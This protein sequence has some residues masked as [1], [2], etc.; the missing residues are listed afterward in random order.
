MKINIMLIILLLTFSSACAEALPP[1]MEP[2]IPVVVEHNDID[3]T[4][5]YKLNR[6]QL[7]EVLVKE[8]I[9]TYC[10]APADDEEWLLEMNSQSNSDFALVYSDQSGHVGTIC[11]DYSGPPSPAECHSEILDLASE[12]VRS[13]LESIGLAN[14]EYPFFYCDYEYKTFVGSTWHSVT[15]VEYLDCGYTSKENQLQIWDRLGGPMVYV[16]V[17]FKVNEYPLA[18]SISWTDNTNRAGNGNPT[19]SAVFGVTQDGKIA[20]ITIRNPFE[21]VDMRDSSEP[22]L[23]WQDVLIMNAP[24][25]ADQMK[26][27]DA[28]DNSL[29][30]RHV[31]LIMMTNDNNITFPAWHFVF[32]EWVCDDYAQ[33]YMDDSRMNGNL[34]YF[35]VGKYFDAVTGKAVLN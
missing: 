6:I 20:A 33:R 27:N 19:P 3:A 31:E 12:T 11:C 30:L 32:E 1:F 7:D 26:K 17:R 21:V 9:D 22:L 35:T 14:Y 28:A 25:I 10:I 34:R 4:I 15:E 18:T 24:L 29:T 5:M 2:D 23:S 8:A 13:F 16:V